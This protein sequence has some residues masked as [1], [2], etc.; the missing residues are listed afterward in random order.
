MTYNRR[1]YTPFVA[2]M[3][4]KGQD[5]P[6]IWTKEAIPVKLD[7]MSIAVLAIAIAA[8]VMLANWASRAMVRT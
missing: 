4:D 7:F 6:L 2:K 3:I 5:L 8:G 1:L